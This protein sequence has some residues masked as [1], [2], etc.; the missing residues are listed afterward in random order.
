[1]SPSE[2]SVKSLPR[3]HSSSARSPGARDWS[4]GIVSAAISW[5]VP[6]CIR[7]QTIGVTPW[8]CQSCHE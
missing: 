6:A 4:T 2:R 8:M 5:G 1:M 3:F 7:T